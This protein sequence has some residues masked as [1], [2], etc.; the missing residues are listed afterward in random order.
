MPGARQRTVDDA[1]TMSSMT[2]MTSMSIDDTLAETMKIDGA[3]GAALADWRTGECLGMVGGGTQLD[4]EAAALCN[5]QV[6]LAK[7]T[8]MQTLG[9]KGAIQDIL[10]TLEDQ[11]HLVRPLRRR[12]SLFL[13]VALDRAS[14]NLA[15]ARHR[16]SKLDSDLKV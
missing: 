2:S 6:V 13:Y 1:A 8:L 7:M 14:T 4:I 9:I 5:C 15:I 16:L 3:I 10:I 11:I 12:T